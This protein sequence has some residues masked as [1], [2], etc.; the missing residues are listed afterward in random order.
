M[1]RTDGIT[2]PREKEGGRRN[3]GTVWDEK[4]RRIV[5]RIR[6]ETLWC[7]FY[8]ELVAQSKGFQVEY[9]SQKKPSTFGQ[10]I[11]AFRNEKAHEKTNG[12]LLEKSLQSNEYEVFGRVMRKRRV[13]KWKRGLRTMLDTKS[14]GK[15]PLIADETLRSRVIS[16]FSEKARNNCCNECRK[17]I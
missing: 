15:W 17:M 8:I 9:R 7:G 4:K 11:F 12:I 14:E 5:S 6:C 16:F 13:D 3:D 1:V 10:S 2:E